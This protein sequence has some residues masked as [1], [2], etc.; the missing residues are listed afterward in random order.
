[1]TDW[2]TSNLLGPQQG[3]H[4]GSGEQINYFLSL[5]GLTAQNS[6]R[7][8]ADELRWLEERFLYPAGFGKAREILATHRTVFLDAAPGSGRIAAAKMLLWELGRDSEQVHELLRQDGPGQRLDTQNVVDGDRAW[9]DLS[10]VDRQLWGEIQTEFS[11]LRHVVQSREAYLVI[12][13]PSEARDLRPEFAQWRVWLERPPPQQVLRR[14]LRVDDVLPSP[15]HQLKL[16]EG[17][18]PLREVAKYARLIREAREKA[19]GTSDFAAWCETAYLALSGQQTAVAELVAQAGQGPQRALLL[20]TAMLHGAHAS[21]VVF[22]ATSLLSRAGNRDNEPSALEEIALG[23]RLDGINAEL[24]VSGGIRFKQIR[25]DAAV[26]TYFWTHFPELHSGL[27]DWVSELVDS[28]ILATEERDRLVMWFAERCIGERY[29]SLWVPLVEQWTSEPTRDRVKASALMLQC[30]LKDE[31]YGRTFRKQIYEWS[32]KKGLPNSRA[33]IIVAACRDQMAATHPDEA[34]VRLHHVARRE[35]GT[36]AREVLLDL[37]TS[38]RRFL[39]QILRRLTDPMHRPTDPELVRRDSDLFL[40]AAGPALLTDPGRRHRALI[41]DDTVRQQ[42]TVGWSHAFA[43][44]T[45][46][47]WG[48]QVGQWLDHAARDLHHRGVLLD[49]LVEA[50]GQHTPVMARLYA[51]TRSNEPRAVISDALLRKI[52]AAQG[53]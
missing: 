33:E 23:R 7:Q 49:V 37:V 36:R 19:D 10:D 21:S 16:P 18:Q 35:R 12:V 50:S 25:Y 29:L 43:R 3:V 20:A 32:R 30:G 31:G 2:V 13:V 52:D 42:L 41:D 46:E 9:L 22:A 34:L 45:D 11:S 14:Y 40:D 48:G 6:L 26:R 47:T 44:T 39:R 51:M 17:K 27:R 53:L 15:A 1:V 5:S 38:D 24:D 8:A 28:Q 4:A